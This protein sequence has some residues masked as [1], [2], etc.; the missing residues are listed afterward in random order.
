VGVTFAFGYR[1]KSGAAEGAVKKAR[2]ILISINKKEKYSKRP[3]EAVCPQG[4][5]RSFGADALYVRVVVEGANGSSSFHPRM[6]ST[7]WRNRRR[8]WD[9]RMA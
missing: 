7:L 1:E 8:A 3:A 5:K 4:A 9:R 6:W 2:N